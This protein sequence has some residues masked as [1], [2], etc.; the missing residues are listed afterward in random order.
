MVDISSIKGGK[1]NKKAAQKIVKFKLTK[2]Q[3]LFV[4]DFVKLNN[5]IAVCRE[6][7]AMWVNYFRLFADLND[8]TEITPEME[9]G[10]FQ[11]AT[12]LSRKHFQYVELMGDCFEKGGDVVNL[13]AVGTSLAVLQGMQEQTRQKFDLDWHTLYLELNKA[14]GRLL[15]MMPGNMTLSEALASVEKGGPAPGA[16]PAVAAAAKK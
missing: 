9:K 14:L 15:R 8:K 1:D 16:R 11:L 6:Y 4:E 12:Q 7:I 13:L 3:T 10:F 2:E 5:R